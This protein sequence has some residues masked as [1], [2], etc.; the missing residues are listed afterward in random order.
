MTQILLKNNACI[1][2]VAVSKEEDLTPTSHRFVINP[3]PKDGRCEVCGRH[4][5]ELRPFGGP[6]DPLLG[7][8]SGELFVKNYRRGAPYD[9]DT[10]LA[11]LAIK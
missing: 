7:D 11:E 3:P 10:K 8:F 9:E 2:L 5:S 6:G 1:S 4:M